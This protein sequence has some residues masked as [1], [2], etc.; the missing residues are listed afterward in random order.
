MSQI[1]TEARIM[2]VEDSETERFTLTA[3]LNK[4]G[5]TNIDFAA[6]AEEAHDK[7]I[8]NESRGNV[9]DLFLLDLN[10]PGMDGIDLCQII[11]GDRRYKHVPS[12]MVTGDHH[13]IELQ[14]A[15][16]GGVVDFIRKPVNKIE[17]LAR[18]RQALRSYQLEEQLRQ[19]AY[20]DPL[21]GLTNRTVFMDRLE[22]ALK[23]AERNS[24]TVEVLFL[25]LNRF[26]PLND[27]LGHEAG[28]QALRETAW[29]LQNIVR[30]SDTVS[31][32]GG[33]EF[34]ILINAPCNQDKGCQR[35]IREIEKT[36]ADPLTLHGT[37]WQLGVSI[38]MARYPDDAAT[39]SELLKAADHSMYENKQQH[40][41]SE[42]G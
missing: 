15:F 30:E 19:L 11:K 17:L 32:L 1:K 12:I 8:N 42:P 25:D 40:H 13:S 21:T 6:S 41:S 39:P 37:S 7:V 29:R 31:R 38:G 34:V 9:Y 36:F 10:L 24:G 23:M 27:T 33:D 2:I 5:Y 22:R 26:K 14:R 18:V 20:H 35:I 16:D 3:M 28:D 4:H